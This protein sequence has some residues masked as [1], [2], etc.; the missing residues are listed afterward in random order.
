LA[1]DA[2]ISRCGSTPEVIEVSV[3][4]KVAGSEEEAIAALPEILAYDR[5]VVRQ[6]FEDKFTS[7]RMAKDYVSIYCRLLKTR[8]SDPRPHQINNSYFA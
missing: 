8:T 6:R 4:G 5:R 7:L 2:A 1:G 3:T